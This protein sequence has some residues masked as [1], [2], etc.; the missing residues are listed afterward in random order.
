MFGYEAY[1]IWAELRRLLAGLRQLNGSGPV[2]A[3]GLLPPSIRKV[4]V[5][6]RSRAGVAAWV[7]G[8]D[9]VAQRSSRARCT[10]RSPKAHDKNGDT[11]LWPT[12][13]ALL[14]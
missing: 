8:V 4:T 11:L 9:T 7:S 14:T 2:A 1:E 5:R 12:R 6:L 13:P 10:G 3:K